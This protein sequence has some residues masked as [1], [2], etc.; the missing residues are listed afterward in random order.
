MPKPRSVWR[1]EVKVTLR[2]RFPDSQASQEYVVQFVT[3]RRLTEAWDADPAVRGAIEGIASHLREYRFYLKLDM[4]TGDRR[5][6]ADTDL[7]ARLESKGR[8]RRALAGLEALYAIRCNMFH[9]HK[10][11][12]PVQLGLLRPAVVLLESTIE[13]LERSLSEDGG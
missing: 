9:A 7:L 5:P 6:D 10:G 11:F 1:G 3:A 8:N 12:E 13:Q 4:V 2:N